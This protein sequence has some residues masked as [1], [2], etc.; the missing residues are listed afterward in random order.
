MLRTAWRD[1]WQSISQFT[2][3]S[4][5]FQKVSRTKK[6]N[7]GTVPVIRAQTRQS[8]KPE[9]TL[10]ISCKLADRALGIGAFEAAGTVN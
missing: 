3:N 4:N 6:K 10:N 9:V 8:H 5:I 7:F 2:S 1:V